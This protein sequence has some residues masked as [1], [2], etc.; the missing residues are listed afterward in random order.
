MLLPSF[1]FQGD[2]NKKLKSN[3]DLEEQIKKM[4]NSFDI[5]SLRHKED[6][7]YLEEE[8]QKITVTIQVCPSTRWI[9]ELMKRW[10]ASEW[11][12]CLFFVVFS[13]EGDQPRAGTVPAEAGRGGE[14]G[15]EGEEGQPGNTEVAQSRDRRDSGGTRQVRPNTISWISTIWIITLINVRH[16]VTDNVMIELLFFFTSVLFLFQCIDLPE[17][18]AKRKLTT[19]Q[20]WVISSSW[21]EWWATG[22][23]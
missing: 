14:E 20:S 19:T 7:A 18:F 2:I 4:A 10:A 6:V 8:V 9:N 1:F 17:P 3:K 11:L 13:C 15:P 23:Y 5:V 16:M 21:G 22:V 12:N